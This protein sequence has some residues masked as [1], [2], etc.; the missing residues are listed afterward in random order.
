MNEPSPPQVLIVE[1]DLC[2]A[3]LYKHLIQKEGFGTEHCAD[4]EQALR[5]LANGRFDAVIL[6]LMLPKLD[7]MQVLKA[8]R[9]LPGNAL[10]PVIIVTAAK[11]QVVEQE[12]LRCGARLFLDKTQHDKLV[13]GLK[14]CMGDRAALGVAKLR[15]AAAA[16]IVP[17]V[18]RRPAV[19]TS[20]PASEPE[21]PKG[22]SRF[23]RRT[24]TSD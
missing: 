5:A 1:D 7:G 19:A 20:E 9:S 4:G 11:L 17:P 12:A 3:S 15:M 6:D 2:L 14:D 13:A 8:M 22:L 10:T 24:T 23:F 18:N 21:A 16:P